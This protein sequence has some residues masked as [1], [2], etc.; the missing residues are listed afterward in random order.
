MTVVGVPAGSAIVEN[1]NNIFL[2]M[3]SSRI[4]YVESDVF[5][6]LGRCIA[7]AAHFDWLILQRIF[8]FR[9]FLEKI[10]KRFLRSSETTNYGTQVQLLYLYSKSITPEVNK[11]VRRRRCVGAW[12]KKFDRKGVDRLFDDSSS[13][14]W[15][16]QIRLRLGQLGAAAVATVAIS[17]IVQL[18]VM[19]YFTVQTT[20]EYKYQMLLDA[21]IAIF[22]SGI[23]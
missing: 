8:L 17:Y 5:S 10:L 20:Q 6:K 13:W 16:G 22:E 11:I 1:T 7:L 14:D 15:V 2:L 9:G 23:Q 21:S 12:G 19:Y 4:F 18:L 3:R